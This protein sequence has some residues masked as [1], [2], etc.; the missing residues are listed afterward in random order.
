MAL[1]GFDGWMICPNINP[2]AY[3][4]KMQTFQNQRLELTITDVDL[5]GIGV[6]YCLDA[7]AH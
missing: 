6:G 4:V 7:H 1:G 2:I 5:I 3:W